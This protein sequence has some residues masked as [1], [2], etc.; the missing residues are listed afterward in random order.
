M[1]TVVVEKKTLLECRAIGKSFGGVAALEGVDFDLQPSEVHGLVGC[2]GAGK[3]TLMKILAGAHPDHAGSVLIEG[4][5]VS[6]SSPREAQACGIAMVYQ[7]LS[8]I[9]ALSV[10]E[11]LFLG[12]QPT[13]AG[14]IDW[15]SMRRQAQNFLSEMQIEV[16]V[17]RRLDRFP[18]VIRQMVEIARGLHS[19]A[20][21]LILDEPTSAFSPP[22]T[23]RLFELI[24]Q[25]KRNGVAVIFISHF[26]E[27]VLEICDRVTVLKDGRKVSTSLAADLT[28]AEVITRMLGRDAGATGAELD[29][30]VTLPA[31]STAVPALRVAGVSRKGEFNDVSFDVAPGECVGLYGFVGAGHQE[32]AHAVAGAASVDAGSV[33]LDQSVLPSGDVSAAVHRGV[34]MVAADRAKTLVRRSSIARNTTLAHLQRSMGEWL[35]RRRE[36]AVVRPLLEQ[37]GCRPARPELL[38]GNLSGGN[39]QKVVLAKWLLGPVRALVLEE[40]T[41]GMDVGAKDEVMRLVAGLKKS[42]AAVVL[43]STEPELVL[44][45][46]D[47]I[48]VFQRGRIAHEFAGEDVRKADLL[49][50][51]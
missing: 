37:V 27:D 28:K 49:R 33:S 30:S 20:R 3:S 6:L 22:E 7:E 48:L 19:G 41:R 9:G 46:A 2:N 42:G 38:A 45:H 43:A 11:N 31:R 50:W 40:P 17:R 16:D 1:S 4:R 14:R 5:E 15:G 21:V 29:E 24:R 32:L 26:L 35:H 25:L 36:H 47:R 34:V 44:A 18:L 39:Q 23:R 10:A 51:A 13:R 12:R 8:G